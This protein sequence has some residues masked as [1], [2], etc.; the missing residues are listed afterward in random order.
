MKIVQTYYSYAD[1]KNPIY[2]MDKKRLTS[3]NGKPIADNQ[4]IQTA[5]VRLYAHG[6]LTA[7]LCEDLGA[8]AVRLFL[9]PLDIIPFAVP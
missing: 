3:E 9:F 2:D 8:L 5:D 6:H 7:D 4:N 1:N